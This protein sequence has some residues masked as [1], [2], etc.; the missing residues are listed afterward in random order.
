MLFCALIKQENKKEH[1]KDIAIAFYQEEG[2]PITK[3]VITSTAGTI[4]T[5][6][7]SNKDFEKQKLNI[8]DYY[9]E[10]PQTMIDSEQKQKAME[11]YKKEIQEEKKQKRR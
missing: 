3:L 8:K 7:P 9:F 2:G 11:L 4:S 6:F 10:K 5:L 1:K